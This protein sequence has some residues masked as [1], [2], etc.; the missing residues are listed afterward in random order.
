[1]IPC[2]VQVVACV[3][4]GG[5]L[6][7][8]P[9]WTAGAVLAWTAGLGVL[10]AC[11]D[12]ASDIACGVFSVPAKIGIGPALWVSRATHLTSVGML[13]AVGMSSPHLSALYFTGVAIAA[14]LLIVEQNLVSA[15]DL[16]KLGLAF[17]T[18]NGIISLLLGTLG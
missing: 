10:Y 16:S 6:V 7:C 18:V 12:Y 17:F 2:V 4:S 15:D 1:M 13:V 8:P 14:A 5:R 9:L 3:A 11:Q